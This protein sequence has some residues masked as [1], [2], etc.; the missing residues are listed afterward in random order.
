MI[1]LPEISPVILNSISYFDWETFVNTNPWSASKLHRF[2]G[3]FIEIS[4]SL[5][6]KSAVPLISE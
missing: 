6:V 3:S 5:I 4:K 2:S 1:S